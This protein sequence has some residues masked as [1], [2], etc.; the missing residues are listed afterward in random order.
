VSKEPGASARDRWLVRVDTG[1]TFTDGWARDP[2]GA[3]RRCKV[4]SSGV[5]RSTILDGAGGTE[6]RLAGDFGAADGVLVGFRLTTGALV[7][8][9]HRDERLLLLDRDP[10]LAAGAVVELGTGEEAPVVAAR[11]LT[12][13]APHHPFPPMQF[14]LAT[15]K[16]TNALLERTGEAGVLLVTEGF[17]DLLRIRDQR[18]PELFAL[19]QEQVPP[20]FTRTVGVR[21]RI[22]ADGRILEP[23]D[24][25]ALREEVGRLRR[26]GVKVA[27]VAL[28]NA[29]ANPSHERRVGE[30][31]RDAGMGHVS[32]SQELAGGVRLLPRAE[33]AVA[34]AYLAPVMTRFVEAV[35][36]GCG[37]RDLEL[38]TSAGFLKPA[39]R[40]RPMDSLLSGPAGGV[41]GALAAAQAAGFDRVLA[42]DMGGTSTDVARLE[43]KPSFRYE[44][45]IGPVRVMAPAVRIETVAAGGGSICRWRNGGLE[46]GPESAG[47]N[48]GPASY[49]RGGPLTITDVNLLS[50]CMDAA[51]A[52][53]PLDASA[54]SRR[55]EELKRV[56]RDEGAAVPSDE[57]LLE[58]LREIAVERMADAIRTVSLRD[59][60]DPAGYVLVAFGGAGPQ[61]A[62]AVAA[63]LGVREI[64]VPGDAGLLSAWGLHR[65]ARQSIVDRQVLE[66][67]GDGGCDLPELVAALAQQAVDGLAADATVSRYLVELRLRGQDAS[68]EVEFDEAP[69]PAGAVSAFR[70]KYESLYGYDVPAGRTIE[71]VALR[72]VAAER[73]DPLEAEVFGAG[74][75]P[76]EGR[77]VM[78][79]AFRTCVVDPGWEVAEGSRGGLLM[80]QIAG[81]VAAAPAWSREVEAELFRCRFENVVGEMGELLRRTA[82][83]TNVKERL[84]FSCALLDRDGFLVVNAPHIPVHLG[85][86]G[87][88]VRRVSE[89]RA[90]KRGDMIVVNHPGFGGSHLPDITV[91]S[92]VFDADGAL[93]AF[94]AN[95]AHHAELGGLS[96]G[97]MP[98]AATCLADE[99]VV[100]P[101]ILLFDGGTKHFAV[102]EAH[103]RAARHP[104]RALDDNLADLAAQAAANRHGVRAMERLAT[105]WS[106]GVVSRNMQ[107]LYARAARI[108]K[109]RISSQHENAWQAED[110]M[111][112]G[113]PLR[114]A[115]RR[116]DDGLRVDFTGSGGVH[117]GNLNATP[118]IVRSAVLY[119]LRVWV[120]EDLPLNEGLL[121]GV[122]L[123]IPH[124]VLNPGFTEADRD[125]PA[126]VGGNVE[127][128]QR[129]VD[130]LLMALGLQANGQGTMNNLLFGS[131]RFGYYETIGGGSGAGPGW[132]GMSGT[133]VHMSN[134]SITD[135]EILERRYP[136]R[137]REFALR[138]GSGGVG[139]WSGGDGLVREL[140][141]TDGMTVSLL[142]QRR[143]NAPHG[144]H[145]GAGGSPGRQMLVRAD[146]S[147][148]ELPPVVSFVV[149]A[150]ERL[151]IETP[152]GG[153][154][155]ETD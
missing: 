136:V 40:Y 150:S 14:R 152:G 111:D 57:E 60:Y 19:R 71:V 32:L 133:H 92:P 141:F 17:E 44:Q 103:F 39:A 59:G 72:V 9:W 47:A 73:L 149:R 85:A 113:T 101:P 8:G 3:E 23:L 29:Y 20:V 135:P 54:A 112:D 15:T 18:R 51:K 63:K 99:G 41:M 142:T 58:G 77:R 118:A 46:V 27:A 4:L 75:G 97:S 131:K 33:T 86:L 66:E 124:G 121:E 12:R 100:I 154:W 82:I 151:R 102:V 48:P 31:L 110:T 83:S 65:S 147:V 50:G 21:E 24:E 55:L 119:V 126:V 116:R 122:E 95:R 70:Q 108:M 13:T 16:G 123:V 132:H 109:A 45:Q 140:E 88:C 79:D 1:G 129:V 146:G 153:G 42:F 53:I 56:M 155:S 26:D 52:G 2:A 28:L 5:L 25:E 143:L 139:K 10:G 67:L 36:A 11:L 115:I 127:T 62:C 90:W 87:L 134:T 114:V 78:Q 105:Q 6:L 80:R 35:A 117:P 34:N 22:G 125:C 64:L 76:V 148:E 89:G 94:V 98:A 61:H 30:L 145:G 106:S 137:V 96:P 104:S 37:G 43:G 144:A 93:L 81:P 38:M 130:I 138:R 7:T 49:G 120:E 68:L 107:R 74:G 128:S 69:D 91:V 84:D